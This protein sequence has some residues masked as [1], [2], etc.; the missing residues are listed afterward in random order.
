MDWTKDCAAIIPCFNE[1]DRIGSLIRDVREHLPFVLVVDDG[2]TDDTAALATAAGATVVR[3]GSNRGKGAALRVGFQYLRDHGFRWALTM[4]GDGQH[5]AADIPRFLAQAD[6]SDADLII[7]NRLGQSKRIPW[8]RRKV[9]LWMT[10]RLS[11]LTGVPLADSQCGFRLLKLAFL[12][13]VV[14]TADRF[15]IESELLLAVVRAGGKIAFVPVDV[16]YHYGHSK[17]HPAWDTWRWLR[18]WWRS[19]CG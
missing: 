6:A 11:R 16:I 9:N 5:S 19:R 14:L 3:H 12:E 2:S 4:D 18:W 1:G 15:E 8:V 10:H 13:R 17:I 7:G